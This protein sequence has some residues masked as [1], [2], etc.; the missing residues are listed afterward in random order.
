MLQR[1][2][3]EIVGDRAV[4]IFEE[5]EVLYRR[6]V[7]DLRA[8]LKTLNRQRQNLMDVAPKDRVSLVPANDFDAKSFIEQ[9]IELSQEII[10]TKEVLGIAE[11]R[12]QVLFGEMK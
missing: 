3:K 10:D 11:E 1:S 4:S 12:Y 6:T 2:R 7:E 9:D 5:T 8:K